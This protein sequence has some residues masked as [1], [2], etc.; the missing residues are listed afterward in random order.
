MLIVVPYHYLKPRIYLTIMIVLLTASTVLISNTSSFQRGIENFNLAIQTDTYTGSWGHRLGYA[1]IGIEIF[2]ENPF[3]G[4][5]IDD[6]TRPIE[7]LSEIHPKYFI[8][9]DLRYIHNEH[10]NTLISVGILGY[11]L[12]LYFFFTL[13]KL[14]IKDKKIYAFKNTVIFIL[15]FVMMG[16]HYLSVKETVNFTFIF[17]TLILTYKKLENNKKHS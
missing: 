17:F 16:D 15:L 8:G 14:H 1:I 3:I 12:L 7:K 5:G 6:V 10:I 2:R 11:I 13:F 9:E 4:R